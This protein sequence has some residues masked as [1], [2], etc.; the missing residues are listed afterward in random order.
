MRFNVDKTASIFLGNTFTASA[1]FTIKRNS[2]INANCHIDVR[3]GITIGEN[4][5]VSERV[6]IVTGDHNPTDPYFRARFRPVLINNHVFVGYGS[7]ILGNV[8]IGEGAVIAAGS[9]VTRD[10]EPYTIVA[11][12]PAQKIGLRTR[13]LR[14]DTPYSRLFH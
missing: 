8:T 10:V 11:G 7:T 14:R 4:V 1:H 6:S 12:I 13:E 9:I 2:V 3:G 5:S